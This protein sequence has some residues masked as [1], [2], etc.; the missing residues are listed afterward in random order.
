M[1]L[2]CYFLFLF[3]LFCCCFIIITLLV[4]IF[5]V[6]LVCWSGVVAVL[7]CCC[8]CCCY[9]NDG[10]VVFYYYFVTLGMF[11]AV[12]VVYCCTKIYCFLLDGTP[13]VRWFGKSNN[14]HIL[15]LDL[16]GPSLSELFSYCSKKFSLQ[17]VLLLAQQMVSPAFLLFFVF[18]VCSK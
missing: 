14:C 4:I 8:C 5:A 15:I 17:T 2:C 3:T 1:F 12:G 9:V 10:F 11:F 18:C 16:L 13:K 6:I 7:L